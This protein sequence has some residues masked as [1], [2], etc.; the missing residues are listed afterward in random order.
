MKGNPWFVWGVVL[1]AA[2][3]LAVEQTSY[4]GAIWFAL[5]SVGCFM[6]SAAYHVRGE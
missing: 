3:A 6:H 5:L 4:P 2:S 1:A